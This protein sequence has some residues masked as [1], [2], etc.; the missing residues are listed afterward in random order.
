MYGKVEHAVPGCLVS[1]PYRRVAVGD[2]RREPEGG[3]VLV[4]NINGISKA[5][6]FVH[7]TTMVHTWVA[8]G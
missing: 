2:V 3:Y 5:E 8:R 7:G 4:T 6:L 1:S